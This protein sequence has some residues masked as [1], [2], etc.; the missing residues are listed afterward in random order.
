MSDETKKNADGSD[1]LDELVECLHENY[2]FTGYATAICDDC[3]K[4]IEWAF[5]KNCWIEL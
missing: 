5:E 2:K 1:R 3:G 4:K